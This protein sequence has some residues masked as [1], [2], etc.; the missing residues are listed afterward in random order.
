M[1]SIETKRQIKNRIGLHARPAAMLVE[2][3]NRFASDIRVSM[4]NGKEVNA[5]SILGVLSLD[6]TCGVEVTI[7]AVGADAQDAMKA[8]LE[9]FDSEFST[10]T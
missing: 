8:I 2:T 7:R 4:A 1:A 5:K 9:L 3:A 10:E 6:A